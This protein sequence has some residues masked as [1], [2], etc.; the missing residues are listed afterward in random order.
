MDALMA[1]IS[2]GRYQV[3]VRAESLVVTDIVVYPGGMRAMNV[4]A[5]AGDINDMGEL[6]DAID[7][8]RASQGIERLQVIGRKGWARALKAKGL[9]PIAVVYAREI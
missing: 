5:A 2:S 9:K 6:L 3:H 1:G 8:R 7:A 4:I